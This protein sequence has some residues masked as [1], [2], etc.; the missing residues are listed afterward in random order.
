VKIVRAL[1]KQHRG[2]HLA[3]RHRCQPKKW[4]QSDGG[5]WKKLAAAHR[6]MI[7]HAIPAWRKG[8]SHQGQG[9]DSVAKG[10]PIG[11][12]LGG[13]NGRTRKAAMQ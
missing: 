9:R 7:C 2:W 3:V 10:A 13:D 4:T 5:S 1:K 6:R 11:R 8:H 12:S